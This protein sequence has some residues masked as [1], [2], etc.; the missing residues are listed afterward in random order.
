[1]NYIEQ[2]EE[3]LNKHDEMLILPLRE[4]Q[5]TRKLILHLKRK[6]KNCRKRDSLNAYL[7]S[8]F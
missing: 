6:K 7:V 3:R 1:M 4:A 2:Q 8:N 5:E